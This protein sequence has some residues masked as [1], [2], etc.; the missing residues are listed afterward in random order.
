M[1]RPPKCRRVE[2]LPGYTYFKPAGVPMSELSEVILSV[3]ELEAIR[4][5]DLTG[6]EHEACAVKMNVSRPT[7]H[8]VLASARQKIAR[9]L[10]NGE[11]LRVEGGNFKLAQHKLKCNSCGHQWKGT[12]CRRRTMC[13][14]CYGNEWQRIES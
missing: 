7:F 5:R 3:E 1:P 9:A 14:L 10:V 11:A 6:I 12:I 2:Q 8:R 4:L 13:P